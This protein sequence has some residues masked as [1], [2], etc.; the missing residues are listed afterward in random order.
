MGFDFSSAHKETSRICAGLR[1][2]ESLLEQADLHLEDKLVQEANENFRKAFDE[3]APLPLRICGLLDRCNAAS[4]MSQTDEAMPGEFAI[5]NSVCSFETPSIFCCRVAAPP[6]LRDQR[7]AKFYASRLG[8]EIEKSVVDVLSNRDHRFRE[9]Y[10]IF[11]NYMDGSSGGAQ[12][13]YD[14]D[15]L[16]IKR[17]LD[18]IISFVGIDDAAKYCSNLYSYAD[19][20]SA[21]FAIYAVE[22]GHLCEWAESHPEV[23]LAKEILSK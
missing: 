14:N 10:A 1:R 16:L 18:A 2:S 19:G 21:A 8:L 5:A 6:F 22:K 11:V 20:E 23:F 3:L 13:Y 9:L 15:N 7:N 12:P 4:L 17:M